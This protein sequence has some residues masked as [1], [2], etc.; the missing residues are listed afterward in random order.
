MRS[1][2]ASTCARRAGRRLSA[3]GAV[4]ADGVQ[5]PAGVGAGAARRG[6]RWW[7]CGRPRSRTPTDRR[8]GQPATMPIIASW[9]A[10]S[11]S[12]LDPAIAPAHGVDAVVVAAQQRVEGAPVAAPGRRRRACGRRRPRRCASRRSV[13]AGQRERELAER[14]AVRVGA[15]A[16]RCRGRARGTARAAWRAGDRRSSP[17]SRLLGESPVAAA[18]ARPSRRAAGDLLGV[19]ARTPR[20][21]TAALPTSKLTACRVA[22]ADSVDDEPDAGLAHERVASSTRS[23]SSSP[24]RRRR[25]PVERARR[26]PRRRHRRGR[27]TPSWRSDRPGDGR[28]G[29]VAVVATAA[30]DAGDGRRRRVGVVAAD[31]RPQHE[32]DDEADGEQHA[33]DDERR[34]GPRLQAPRRAARA[35]AAG[36]RGVVAVRPATVTGSRRRRLA[37]DR[38]ARA[39]GRGPARRRRRGVGPTGAAAAGPAAGGPTRRCASSVGRRLVG[40]AQQLGAQLGA[41]GRAVV[42][43]ARR[44][45]GGSGRRGRAGSVGRSRARSVGSRCRRAS[46]VSASVSP[47]NGTRPARHS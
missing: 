37:G 2:T 34:G 16:R 39:P 26:S 20:P 22:G 8:S 27:T 3:V 40:D 31:R 9:A 45:A 1:T 28:R 47:R 17:S 42:G 46:A 36:V 4:V 10:S 44:A 11:A 13:S 14:A 29:A 25:A 18:A 21:G 24:G 38:S 30:G 43:V 19:G 6:R 12:R 23:S 7:R 5:A 41:G 35:V 15:A 32:G 33:D